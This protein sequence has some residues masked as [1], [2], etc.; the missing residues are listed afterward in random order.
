MTGTVGTVRRSMRPRAIDSIMDVVAVLLV[1]LQL[2]R[3]VVPGHLW[4]GW[5][6]ADAVGGVTGLFLIAYLT[7]VDRGRFLVLPAP[8]PVLAASFSAAALLLAAAMSA[9]LVEAVWDPQAPAWRGVRT[10]IGLLLSIAVL[11]CSVLRF[12]YRHNSSAG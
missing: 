12:R 8:G 2:V 9:N 10:V 5:F 1:S 7:R 11:A 4:P 3:M 6:D